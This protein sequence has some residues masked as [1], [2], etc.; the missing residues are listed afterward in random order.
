MEVPGFALSVAASLSQ[1]LTRMCRCKHVSL[2]RSGL[3]GQRSGRNAYLQGVLP[4][5]ALV[6]MLAWEW[7][8]R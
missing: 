2:R 6:A 3:E 4:G 8:D 5:E 1:P 7:L